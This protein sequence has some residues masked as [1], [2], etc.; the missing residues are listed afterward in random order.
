MG[1]EKLAKHHAAQA[2]LDVTPHGRAEDPFQLGEMGVDPNESAP[3][4]A[5]DSNTDPKGADETSRGESLDRAASLNDLQVVASY[6]AT[7]WKKGITFPVDGRLFI[8]TESLEFKPIIGK[9][10]KLVWN[11]LE[12]EKVKTMHAV[13]NGLQVVGT[14]D[15]GNRKTYLFTM[16]HRDACLQKI[17]NMITKEASKHH[18]DTEEEDEE[19]SSLPVVEPDAILPKMEP[20]VK[21][22]LKGVS[23]Q[24]FYDIVWSE[25][26]DTDREPLYGPWLSSCGKNDVVVSEWEKAKDEAFLNE[27]CGEKYDMKRIV[28]FNFQGG[29]GHPEVTHTQHCRVEGDDRCIFAMTVNMK[30]IPFADSFEVEVRWVA[31]RVGSKDISLTAGLLVNFKKSCM[32]AGK[33]KKNTT[34]E[35]TKAQA[36]LCERMKKACAAVSGEPVVDDDEV[37]TDEL[38]LQQQPRTLATQSAKQDSGLV[39][40]WLAVVAFISQLLGYQPKKKWVPR[41]EVEQNIQCMSNKLEKIVQ[42]LEKCNEQDRKT[43]G[44]NESVK[45]EVKQVNDTLEEVIGHINGKQDTPISK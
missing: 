10:R 26:N 34:A 5:K 3:R 38:Q 9:E 33:I 4:H 27:W 45:S 32:V 18:S 11:N 8:K 35:T 20:I 42:L 28:T 43:F 14:D 7:Y 22:K 21:A 2:G 6:M 13:K 12:V 17:N 1:L 24:D 25:G 29:F 37:D 36:D 39:V 44:E 15:D 41:G 30:G 31:S 40:I 23:V 19:V 16:F